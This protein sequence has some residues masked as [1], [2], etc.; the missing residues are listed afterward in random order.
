MN[1]TFAT[2]SGAQVHRTLAGREKA[3][4]DIVEAAYRAHG[5]GDTVNPPSYFLRF[6]DRPDARIIA[7]PASVGGDV[8]IDGIKWISSTPANVREGLPRASGVLIL[9]DRETGYPI[10]CMEASIVSACRTAASAVLA[11]DCLTRVRARPR[12]LGIIGT[13]LIAR[14]LHSYL[15]GTG[16]TFDGIGLFDLSTEHVAGFREYLDRCGEAAD[17]VVHDSA[18]DLLAACDLTVFATV[19]AVPHVVDPACLAH[20]PLILHVSLRDL[21]PEII[22]GA[23]NIVDDIEHCLRA[24]TSPHLAEQQVGHRGFVA[25]TLYDVLIGRV[26]PAFDRPV[27]FSPFGLGVL[28]LA[29]GNFVYQTLERSGELTP[30]PGF[31]H[32]MK[33]YG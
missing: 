25:G 32:D 15:V 17:I 11:A 7:L 9:N 3:V 19:A 6:P 2:I 1:P 27:I 28:D 5:V 8:Q 26:T 33:R 13:G 12:R 14:Y 18:E 22:L 16:W 21:G 29:V 20:R 24:R 4:V 23:T 10:A 30:V 31:F